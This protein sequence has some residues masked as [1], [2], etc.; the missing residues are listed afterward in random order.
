M[1]IREMVKLEKDCYDIARII[2]MCLELNDEE[3]KI[4]MTE[5]QLRFQLDTLEKCQHFIGKQ[6]DDLE[7]LR[8]RNEPD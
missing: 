6:L 3:H 1:S 8:R 4:T 7:R 5:D 2:K